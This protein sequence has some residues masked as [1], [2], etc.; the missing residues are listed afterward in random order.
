MVGYTLLALTLLAQTDQTV[1]VKK[2]AKLELNNL[3]GDV[4]VRV[5]DRD[6]VRVQVDNGDLD[7]VDV[8]TTDQLVTVRARARNGLPR[9]VDYT[10]T[11]P[12]WM[13]VSVSGTK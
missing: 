5:W 4:N 3:L 6:Q 9:S 1:S 12:T 10:I 2:G 11:V 7:S 8:R 13:A